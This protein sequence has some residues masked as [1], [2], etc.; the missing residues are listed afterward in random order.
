[1]MNK[2]VDNGPTSFNVYNHE[3]TQQYQCV[4]TNKYNHIILAQQQQ[5]YNNQPK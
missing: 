2:A 5:E 1:M 3:I 4:R